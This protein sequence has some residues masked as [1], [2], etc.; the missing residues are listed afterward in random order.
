MK[1]RLLVYLTCFA[2]AMVALFAFG[3]TPD[4]QATSVTITSQGNVTEIDEGKTLQLTAKVLPETVS[5]DVTWKSG[6]EGKASVSATGLVTAK[7]KGN[8]TITATSVATPT[9]SKT[10]ALV[11]NEAAKQQVKPEEIILTTAGN[12][13]SVKVGD[14]L[15]ITA[16]VLPEGAS[17]IISKWESENP[18][19]ATVENGLVKGIAEGK[20]KITAF[21]TGTVDGQDINISAYLNIT[22][23]ASGGA[24]EPSTDYESMPFSTHNDY[25]AAANDTYIKVKGV[26]TYLLDAGEGKVSYYLQ[27]GEDAFYVFEQNS[28]EFPVTVGKAYAVGGVKTVYRTG[29]HEVKTVEYCNELT[30]TMSFTPVDLTGKDVSSADEMYPYHGAVVTGT[31]TLTTAPTVSAT[32]GYNVSVEIGEKSTNL[33]IDPANMGED[34][35][36]KANEIF[37]KAVAGVEISF[38]G[39]MTH[40]GN[41]SVKSPQILIFKT[42]E[43]SVQEASAADQVA[44][45]KDALRV[46][47]FVSADKNTIDLATTSAM[48]GDVTVTWA[49]SNIAIVTNA[50]AVTHP[51]TDTVVTLTATVSHKTETSVTSTKDFKVNIAGKEFT[52]AALVTMDLEDAEAP[53]Q[54]GQSPTKPSYDEGDIELGTPKCNW[55]LKNTMIGGD[56]SD[57]KTGT[58]AFRMQY[59]TKGGAGRVELTTAGDYSYIQFDTAVY[60]TNQLGICLKIE[61]KM[62]DAT[63][64]VDLGFVISV[65]SYTLE[66][67]RFAIPEAGEKTVAVSVVEGTGQRVNIDNL[68][69]F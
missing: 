17:Q 43:F 35:F 55:H 23:S 40:Y 46:M 33:R 30:E 44:I 58:L 1:K 12:A 65:D 51:Q 8:V 21:V 9:V 38:T 7:A 42:S 25:I 11:I 6:D 18:E 66:T 19:I 59:A 60:G 56:G 5:Q 52:R 27:N 37:S 22:V 32:K 14:T 53:G 10:F 29:A 16:T 45:V 50:G 2:L 36:A 47:S 26:V 20:V 57:R 3:C 48:F 31:A 69:L 63:D 34:E 24:T 68:K 61:Y 67:Y 13:T 49:S 39:V 62:K 4:E 54:Y 64:W 41:G 15:K 28:T